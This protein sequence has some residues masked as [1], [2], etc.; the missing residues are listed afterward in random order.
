LGGNPVGETPMFVYP[1]KNDP[2]KDKINWWHIWFR[3]INYG[4][5][6]ELRFQD[7]KDFYKEISDFLPEFRYVLN[8]P[9][10]E[11]YS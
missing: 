9:R 8:N 11:K 2:S 10:L 3:K 1:L 7:C 5:D 6:E 4:Y